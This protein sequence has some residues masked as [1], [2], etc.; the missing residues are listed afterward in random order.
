MGSENGTPSSMMSAPDLTRVCISGTV[1]S[2]FGS[3]AVT[4]G[5]KAVLPASLS[6]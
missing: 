2:G 5:I 1:I 6:S 4:K 3:P